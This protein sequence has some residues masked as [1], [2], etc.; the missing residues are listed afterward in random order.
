MSPLKVNYTNSWRAREE[1][2]ERVKKNSLMLF[3]CVFSA[4]RANLFVI[5]RPF[6]HFLRY[7]DIIAA[8]AVAADVVVDIVCYYISDCVHFFSLC[9]ALLLTR[10]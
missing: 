7:A 10:S 9:S 5:A 1:E 8:A 6:L 4:L 2:S 3:D